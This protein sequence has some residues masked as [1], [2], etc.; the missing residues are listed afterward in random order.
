MKSWPPALRQ[1][2][3]PV[4][5][6]KSQTAGT[7]FTVTVYIT[8]DNWNV[9]ASSTALISI[10]TED[11][12]DIHPPNASTTNGTQTFSVE[13]HR[14]VGEQYR[15]TASTANGETL[16]SYTSPLITS[17]YGTAKKLQILAPGE[18]PVDGSDAGK[19]GSADT[20]VA[21]T[22]NT[23]TVRVVD[24]YFNRNRYYEH[25]RKAHRDRSVFRSAE[26][27]FNQR[28]SERNIR[29]TVHR[30]YHRVADNGFDRDRR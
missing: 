3:Q 2:K 28:R 6:S 11:P 25:D 13:F 1:E 8:D 22:L 9:V 23:V 19:S 26:H 15:V 20:W 21:N 29:D 18:I 24:K 7:A 27:A 10:T 30:D 5:R 4:Q 17:N 14:G 12:Y 16:A